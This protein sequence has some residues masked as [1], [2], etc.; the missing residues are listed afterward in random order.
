MPDFS[1]P[2][3]PVP[4][5]FYPYGGHGSMTVT[6]EGLEVASRSDG[7]PDLRLQFYR[8]QDPSQP[9]APYAVLDIGVQPLYRM[10]EALDTVRGLHPEGRVGPALFT[11]G[12]LRLTLL[13]GPMTLPPDLREPQPLVWNGLT[14]GRWSVQLSAESGVLM[15]EALVDEVLA[16]VATAELEMAGV[17]PRLALRATFD[18]ARLLPALA[19]LVDEQ[20]RVARAAILALFAGDLR[21]IGLEV[22]GDATDRRELAEVLTDWVRV[23]FGTLAPAPVGGQGT[24]LALQQGLEEAGHGRQEW[25]LSQPLRTWRPFVLGLRPLETARQLARAGPIGDLVL[26][27]IMVPALPTGA[28]PVDIRANLPKERPGIVAM[29]VTLRAE[30]NP[31]SR[32]QAVSVSADLSAH[33]DSAH[34]LLRLSPAEKPEYTVT[35]FAIITDSGGAR[36]LQGSASVHR[37]S[38]VYLSIDDFPLRFVAVEAHP[39]LLRLATV[40]GVLHVDDHGTD[41][42]TAFELDTHQAAIALAV[43]VGSQERSLEVEARERQGEG[44]VRLDPLPAMPLRLGLHAFPQYGPHTVPIQA[45]FTEGSALVAVDLLPVAAIEGPDTVTV[46]SL[47]PDQPRREWR[48][49]SASPFRG[50]YRYRL[51]ARSGAV[52]HPWSEV[53][54]PFEGIVIRG[55]PTGADG[56]NGFVGAGT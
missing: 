21:S 48:Y 34:L 40:A 2:L 47:T 15:Q 29:G 30:P 53:R 56:A 23:R 37:G 18:S 4:P 16:L 49:F 22:T 25:D 17:A 44:V 54:S 41:R 55:A 1:K 43:P 27:P 20:G 12:F 11:E 19:D 33:D 9:P 32:P 52:A 45:T 3:V 39:D 14:G 28:V 50:G 5:I 7:S 36:E 31:P 10:E 26:P 6:P 13:D 8:P 42:S 46:L 51:H 24:Y 38:Q 35:T